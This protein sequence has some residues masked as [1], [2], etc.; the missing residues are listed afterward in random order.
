MKNIN[1][2]GDATELTK[3]TSPNSVHLDEPGVKTITPV[4]QTACTAIGVIAD[5]VWAHCEN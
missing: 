5:H 3:G 2:L 4:S 1:Q